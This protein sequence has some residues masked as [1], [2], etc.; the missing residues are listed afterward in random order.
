MNIQP[1]RYEEA[2]GSVKEN[3]R[4]LVES[5]GTGRL[6]IFFQYIGPFPDYLDHITGQICR[7]LENKRFNAV[8][9]EIGQAWASLMSEH[10]PKPVE[11]TAWKENYRLSGKVRL[12]YQASMKLVFLF[13]ALRE[14][15]KGWAVAAKPLTERE[16][17]RFV[18]EDAIFADLSAD[19]TLLQGD[20]REEAE[21]LVTYLD[22]CRV[23]F[24]VLISQTDY[25]VFRVEAEKM[26]LQILPLLPEVVFSP[27]N[28]FLEKTTRYDNYGE[29]LY[30]L[31]EL[32][33][34]LSMRKALFSVYL[35]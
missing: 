2:T 21:A 6:P 10:F 27:I 24:D 12:I 17:Q 32:F 15:V 7:N 35:L 23:N 3:Y 22:M 30:L 1:L 8:T 26:I 9:G 4:K 14:A 25:L 28:V 20:R 34:S 11:I 29:L 31:G 16:E 33:P 5:F 13:I 19:K 18:Y